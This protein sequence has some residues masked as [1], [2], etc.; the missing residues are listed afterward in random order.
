MKPIFFKVDA[1]SLQMFLQFLTTFRCAIKSQNAEMQD[2]TSAATVSYFD[3]SVNVSLTV[4]Q[5]E[6]I[7]EGM[8][9]GISSA[10]SN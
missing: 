8:R 4:S 10:L 3:D 6:R 5:L 7:S 9:T 1:I 2:L